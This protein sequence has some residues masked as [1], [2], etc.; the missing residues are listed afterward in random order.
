MFIKTIA[1]KNNS[2]DKVFI[3]HRLV[4]SYRTEKGAR[5]RNILNLGT[6]TIDNK[7]FKNLADRIEQI[8]AGIEPVFPVEPEIESLAGHFAALLIDNKI[9]LIQEATDNLSE[10]SDFAEV[11]LNTVQTS[12]CR[13]IGLEHIAFDM[14]KRLDFIDIFRNIGFSDSDIKYAVVSI[15]GR[16]VNPVSEN[17]SY[18]WAKNESG[19]EELLDNDFSR[20]SRN[21]LYEIIDKLYDNKDFIESRLRDS[22]KNLFSLKEKILLYDL[23][24][25]YFE[26][27]ALSNKKAKRGRSKEKRYD[28]PIVTLGLIIDEQGF[29]KRSRIL[30]G[31]VSEPETLLT[32]INNLIDQ[33]DM[34]E[35]PTILMDAGIATEENLLMLR[36][37]GYD[38]VCVARNNPLKDF[39]L[40]KVEF[41]MVKSDRNNEVKV[42]MFRTENEHILYCES[43]LKGKKEEA[44]KNMYVQRFE[45]GIKSIEASIHKK[46]GMKSYAKIC[47]RIGRLKE[48][49]SPIC[50]FYEIIIEK[51]END[52]V[53]KIQWSLK[54]Q[55]AIDAKFSGS[56]ALRSSRTDLT[57]EDMWELY[58]VLTNVENTFRV[59]KTDL[60]MRPVHHQKTHRSDGH[61]FI[62]LL[63]YHIVN[64]VLTLL[65]QA[66]EN[67]TWSTIR[68]IM[69]SM[70]RV[71]TTMK[72][73]DGDTIVL[74]TTSLAD[75]NQTKI[76][77]AL[78]LS[79]EPIGRKKI[80]LKL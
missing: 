50:N 44:I 11:D 53:S 21:R 9:K 37:E 38:Y 80:I 71:T 56:Y 5:H 36:N 65:K 62:T 55:S 19:I 57:E 6:L 68:S 49:T 77:S 8:S 67:H 24:N 66:G 25:T 52:I 3:Y 42:K 12:K 20:F 1:K 35:K 23:T 64:S 54:N 60:N 16:V 27:S 32:M 58:T 14:M 78:K 39:D 17:A 45:D 29:P 43:F 63:A 74:R 10:N 30:E 79:N 34:I 69:R 28:C 76:L 22:E 59:L 7:Y 48:Q 13:T 26:G 72:N 15:I 31:N 4:E 70:S 41:S 75:K 61:I 73:R 2:S 33:N 47:E 46:R 18:R 51:N 40:S